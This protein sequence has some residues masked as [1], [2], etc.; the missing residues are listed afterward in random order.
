MT[1]QKGCLACPLLLAFALSL[2]L[3]PVPA[4]SDDSP[5]SALDVRRLALSP[6]LLPAAEDPGLPEAEG[7]LLAQA[8]PGAGAS[9]AAP[10]GQ[11]IFGRAPLR[12]GSW[13]I[14]AL[15]AY[16]ISGAGG[17][18]ADPIVRALWLL[19]R[20]GY[21][22]WEI[23]WYPA[24]VQINLEPAAALIT[25]PTKTYI[26][27]V[28]AI[29]RHTFL[30]WRRVSPYIE[31][32][33]GLMNTNLRH[34]ALGESIEFTPQVGVGFHF[35]VWERGSLSAGFRWLHISNAGLA[36]QNLGLNNYFPYVGFT[37]F[38]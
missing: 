10:Q 6:D 16:S 25:T 2:L 33:A 29:L 31:G 37:I 7:G 12:Q 13:E 28:N 9:A 5:P 11:S 19:P 36:D 26:L 27:G 18:K 23:P 30:V 35:H 20:I 1:D 15:A 4:S 32:G 14:G 24:S 22:F 17:P 8:S 21:T 34:R 38:F 3:I